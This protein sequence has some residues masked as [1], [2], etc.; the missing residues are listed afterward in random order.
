MVEILTFKK[1]LEISGED[2]RRKVLLGNGFS[3]ACKKD[4]FAYNALLQEA[5]FSSVSPC[6]RNAFDL[7]ET[8]DFEIIVKKLYDAA[9]V[10]DLY[11]DGNDI[12]RKIQDD[13]DE[14]KNILVKVLAVKHPRRPSEIDDDQYNSCIK[15]LSKF[16]TIYTLNYDLL[17]Y[18]TLM[19]GIENGALSDDMNDGFATSEDDEDYVVWEGSYS[20]NQNV[21]FLHGALHIFDKGTVFQKLTYKNTNVPLIEQIQNALDDNLYPHFVAEGTAEEK[22]NRIN[23]SI[24]LN[25]GFKSLEGITGDLFIYGHSLAENDQH[26][27]DKIEKGKIKNVFISLYGDPNSEVNKDIRQRANLLSENR[28]YLNAQKAKHRKRASSRDNEL[29]VHFYDAESAEIWG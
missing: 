13:A 5:D 4:I 15:F 3:I 17:L 11:N 18:W 1:A 8:Q 20:N 2:S 6:V 26:V 25:K 27:L 19:H 21:F 12:S 29:N 7:F 28:K 23:H 9:K 14:L 22:L 10:L 24:F 16:E